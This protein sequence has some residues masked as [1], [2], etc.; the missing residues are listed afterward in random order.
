MATALDLITE[1]QRLVAVYGGTKQVYLV[2]DDDT[3]QGVTVE[4]R[5][6][7]PR[8]GIYFALRPVAVVVR[9]G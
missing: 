6:G 8:E 7:G 4:P 9:H 2:D 3:R 5:P 1:L